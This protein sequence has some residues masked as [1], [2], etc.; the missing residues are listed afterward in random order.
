MICVASSGYFLHRS[1]VKTKSWNQLHKFYFNI[2]QTYHLHHS[3]LVLT[4]SGQ[5]HKFHFL[6]E[7]KDERK[8]KK[9]M[10]TRCKQHSPSFIQIISL[11]DHCARECPL[12]LMWQ[13]SYINSLHGLLLFCLPN[14][15]PLDCSDYYQC[16]KLRSRDVASVV[17]MHWFNS[18]NHLRTATYHEFSLGCPG[19]EPWVRHLFSL[20]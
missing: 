12:A 13:Q 4:Y 20:V 14:I 8:G 7:G 15:F 18:S 2:Y 5:P 9:E 17:N 11:Q 10:N 6:L 3:S 19:F 16:H 1:L